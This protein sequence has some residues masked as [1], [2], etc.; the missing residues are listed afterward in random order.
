MVHTA[1]PVPVIMKIKLLL[2][3]KL[4]RDQMS[5]KNVQKL[6]TVFFIILLGLA[7][8]AYRVPAESNTSSAK[9]TGTN[10]VFQN[11]SSVNR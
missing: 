3:T 10:P 1:H 2:P 5:Q 6:A 8:S 7:V 11:M 4:R 9:I